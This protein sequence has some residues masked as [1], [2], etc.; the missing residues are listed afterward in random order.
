MNKKNITIVSAYY[1]PEETAI[2]LYNTQLTDFLV[3]KGYNV[4][5]ITGFPNYPQWKIHQSYKDLPSYYTETLN[6]VEVIRYKQYVPNIVNFKGRVLLMLTLFYGT[7]RNIFKIK[8]SDLVICILPFSIN[9]I[10]AKFL[11]KRMKA[12]FWV[13]VQDFEFDLALDS[14]V[15]KQ[16][17]LFFKFFK[18][19]LSFFESKMLNSADIVS[20]I[21]NSMLKKVKEKSLHTDPFYFPN[22]VSSDK[23]N[24]S[25]S[26]KHKLVSPN[27]FTVL[28]SGNIGEKQN[29][30]FLENL[31][32]LVKETDA[33]EI[34]IVGDGAYKNNLKKQLEKFNFV[35]FFDPVPYEELNDLLCSVDVHF[36]FQ[37]N[38]VIDTVMP[39]KLLAMMASAKPSII[40]G[41]KESEV[42]FIINESKGGYYFSDDNVLSVYNQI[43]DLKKSPEIGLEI[44][45]KARSYVLDRFS[46]NKVLNDFND[47]LLSVL[48]G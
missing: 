45:N 24:P 2:G 10:P 47:K 13:H 17:N 14:G 20:S 41:N 22:W 5:I 43:I 37:K 23:I 35:K 7:F 3:Q 40:T 46:S 31:C 25:F 28:Y 44:G 29:W 26:S 12:K 48:N 36:L 15:V 18:K 38:E 1:Y 4:K 39:S 11:S 42:A 9:M 27:M 16:S 32:D 30:L 8:K 19:T 33:I 6:D 34:I 21:S